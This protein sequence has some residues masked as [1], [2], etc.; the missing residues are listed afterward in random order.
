MLDFRNAM[1]IMIPKEEEPEVITN[2]FGRNHIHEL[3]D[4]AEKHNVYYS[5]VSEDD[6][7]N[8]LNKIGTA[9]LRCGIISILNLP[10]QL[11][12]NQ[13]QFFEDYKEKISEKYPDIVTVLY[14]EEMTEYRTKRRELKKEA[15]LS[16][17]DGS[18]ID[19]L[20]EEIEKQKEKLKQKER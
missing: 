20:Y 8:E 14:S 2:T 9:V 10:I 4:Y 12:S 16:N 13:I 18:D 11:S 19:L 5:S 3:I 6:I 1:L 17:N 15:L 7:I